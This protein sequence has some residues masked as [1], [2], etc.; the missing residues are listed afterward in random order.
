ME[1]S[2]LGKF[3]KKCNSFQIQVHNGLGYLIKIVHMIN[4]FVTIS[5]LSCQIHLSKHPM[6][7]FKSI[8][9]LKAMSKDILLTINFHCKTTTKIPKLISLYFL[10]LI[11]LT[12]FN[13][14]N[15]MVYLVLHL[16]VISKIYSIILYFNQQIKIKSQTQCCQF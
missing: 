12:I 10:M 13:S 4:V 5:Y 7:S 14:S 3:I 2:M 15:Q 16:L 6:K 8:T 9:V 1:M 11:K